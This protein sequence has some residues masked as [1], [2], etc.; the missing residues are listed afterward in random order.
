MLN[1][2]DRQGKITKLYQDLTP[3]DRIKRL[4]EEKVDP[5]L[6]KQGFKF[7]RSKNL[8]KRKV[9]QLTQGIYI[10]KSKW[11]RTE[12]AC[13]FWLIFSVLADNYNQWHKQYYGKLPLNNAV[14]SFYHNHLKNWK[15]KYKLDKY[16][17]SKQDNIKVFE[18]IKGN[19]EKLILPLFDKF[20]DYEK[21]ADKLMQDREYWWAAKIY[22]FYLIAGKV[23]KAK[24]ALIAG[25]EYYDKIAD[26]Q[27]EPLDAFEL[28]LKLLGSAPNKLDSL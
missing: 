25:K 16:D 26:P 10:A 18:E 17:L 15:T 2:F 21:S 7:I 20:S 14:T 27:K 22:D 5:Y 1:L 4:F 9:G 3:G 28:R 19:L 6:T 8:F 24:Q 12:G 23:D 13:S 11:N